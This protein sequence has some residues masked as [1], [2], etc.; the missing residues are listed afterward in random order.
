MASFL[1]SP[2]QAVSELIGW[3]SCHPRRNPAE[4]NHSSV[5]PSL[6]LILEDF[7][8]LGSSKISIEQNATTS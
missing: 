4:Q 6:L 5:L 3:C 2:T 7:T 1:L 8:L